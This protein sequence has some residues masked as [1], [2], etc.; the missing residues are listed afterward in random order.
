MS[1]E[2]TIMNASLKVIQDGLH[3]FGDVDNWPSEYLKQIHQTFAGRQDYEY[4]VDTYSEEYRYL[5]QL[6]EHGFKCPEILRRMHSRGYLDHQKYWVSKQMNLLI[7]KQSFRYQ[8]DP[9]EKRELQYYMKHFE[10]KTHIAYMMCRSV[11]WVD[12]VSKMYLPD[13]VDE[14]TEQLCLILK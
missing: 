6:T 14:Y 5:K 3:K 13:D 4:Y 8:I 2:E 10:G 11:A 7:G 1:R 12:A 9:D